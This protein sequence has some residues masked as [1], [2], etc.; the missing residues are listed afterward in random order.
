MLG[1]YGVTVTVGV[2]FGAA[3]TIT[4]FVPDAPLYVV[5]LLASGA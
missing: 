5:E 1:E 2:I 3:V 4:E